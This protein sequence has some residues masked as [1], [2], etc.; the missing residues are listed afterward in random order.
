MKKVN[1]VAAIIEYDGE[2][3][4]MQRGKGKYDY[5]SYKYEFPGGKVEP[6]ESLVE[7]LIREIDEEMDLKIEVSE[8]DF[9]MKIEHQ[10]PDF[11]ITMNSYRSK[12]KDRKFNLKEHHSFVWLKTSE[13]K[14]LDWADADKPII[15]KLSKEI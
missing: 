15:D 5:I 7:A 14:K 3:L 1:V 2:I 10:Y 6:G 13:L 12:V 8:Q 4:C 11:H 9:F